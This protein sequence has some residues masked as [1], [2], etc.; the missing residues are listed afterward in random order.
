M[1]KFKSQKEASR[2]AEGLYNTVGAWHEKLRK[3]DKKIDSEVLTRLFKFLPR[4]LS[5]QVMLDAGCG[6]GIFSELLLKRGAK[7]AVCVD[8]SDAMLKFARKRKKA[9]S[10][11]GMDIRKKDF[12]KTGFPD[13]TFDLIIAIYSLP[14]VVDVKKVFKEFSRL[15]KIGGLLFIAS[16]FYKIKKSSLRGTKIR[17]L[18][19]EMPLTGVVHTKDD[20][21]KAATLN[22]FSVEDFFVV[23]KAHGLRIDPSYKYKNFVKQYTFSFVLQKPDDF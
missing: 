22:K 19:G 5:G 12:T 6:S 23:E 3:S 14:Y 16:D 17:Y 4:N 2:H 1:Q 8:V 20:Y 10:L 13:K 9:A 18:L 21:L 11:R 7:K 15:L